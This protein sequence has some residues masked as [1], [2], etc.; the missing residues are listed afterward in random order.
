MKGFAKVLLCVFLF[1]F[2]YHLSSL[3]I[4]LGNNFVH[5]LNNHNSIHAVSAFISLILFIVCY[6]II[7]K[8]RK[9]YDDQHHNI[10]KIRE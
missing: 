5:L 10:N 2:L 7:G 8:N 6:K 3:L 9:T 4:H 1:G